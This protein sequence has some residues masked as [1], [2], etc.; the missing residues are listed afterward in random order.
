MSGDEEQFGWLSRKYLSTIRRWWNGSGTDM[1]ISAETVGEVTQ[2][3]A[4]W[5]VADPADHS[6][7][8][9]LVYPELRRIAEYR[10]RRERWDHTLQA[11]A[12]VNEFV[13]Q[14]Y[15]SPRVLLKDRKHLLA[16]ASQAMRNILVDYARSQQAGKR[17]GQLEKIPLEGVK[18]ADSKRFCDILELNELLDRL[19]AEEPRMA[20]V[21]ELRYF[22][23]LSNAE[24]ADILQLNER[25]VKRD[26]QVAR[27]WL[28]TQLRGRP[29][30]LPTNGK[31]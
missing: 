26:W 31:T 29:E 15:S 7:L 23:G 27:A 16:A 1:D 10:M 18:A 25:T 11:T 28:Y 5:N 21:V 19:A 17:G 2:L 14:L 13:A 12:L 8:L 20:K 24:I 6:R 22:G 30:C 3:L 9:H 4:R